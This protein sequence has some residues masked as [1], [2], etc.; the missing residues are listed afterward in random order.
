[1]RTANALCKL[2]SSGVKNDCALASGITLAGIVIIDLN[3]AAFEKSDHFLYKFIGS[4]NV[5]IIFMESHGAHRKT[6]T[7][8]RLW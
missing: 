1:M 3:V 5:S 7:Y 4:K 8:P 2:P 6:T